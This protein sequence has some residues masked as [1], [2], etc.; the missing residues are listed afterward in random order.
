MAILKARDLKRQTSQQEEE[1]GGGLHTIS[2]FIFLIFGVILILKLLNF[3]YAFFQYIPETIL[4]WIAAIGS[5]IG[6]LYMIYKK[7]LYRQKLILK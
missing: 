2:A 1:K 7:Y 5:T 4:Y 3:N 6:G